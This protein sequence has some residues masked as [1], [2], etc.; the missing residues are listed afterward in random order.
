[1]RKKATSYKYDDTR[2]GYARRHAIRTLD[3][4]EC[5][6]AEIIAAFGCSRATFHRYDMDVRLTRRPIQPAR[7]HPMCAKDAR[8]IAIISLVRLGYTKPE[9]AEAMGVSRSTV[10]R[11]EGLLYAARGGTSPVEQRHIR[12]HLKSRIIDNRSKLER[13]RDARRRRDRWRRG[14]RVGRSG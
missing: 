9:I 4:Y 7:L 14:Y 13:E 11:Q 5:S 10:Y 12:R 3:E 2:I 1:M 8:E 6:T